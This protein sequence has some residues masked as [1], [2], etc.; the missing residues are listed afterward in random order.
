MKVPFGFFRNVSVAPSYDADAIAY[1]NR[2]TVAGGTLTT[3]EKDAAN[4][5]VLSMKANNIWVKM[6][7]VY[8]MLG[9][10]AASC[11][12]NLISSI[13]TGGFSSGWTYSSLGVKGNGTSTYMNT[14]VIPFTAGLTQNDLHMSVYINENAKVQAFQIGARGNNLTDN[15]IG[16]RFSATQNFNCVN[17]NGG[18]ILSETNDVRGFLCVSRIISTEMKYYKFGAIAQ[19]TAINS[20]SIA[21]V[22]PVWIGTLNLIGSV[23][24]PDTARN[25]FASVGFGLTDG[26]EGN[27]STAVTAFQ[28]SLSRA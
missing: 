25:C 2:V 19:T 23:L 18:N 10:S 9:G 24:Y 14:D 28:T 22:Y 5:L 3:T 16:A 1:F 15:I 26:Q 20:A 17:V 27:L 13:F 21:D 8:P 11:A 6:K 12:Q 4:T 7:A